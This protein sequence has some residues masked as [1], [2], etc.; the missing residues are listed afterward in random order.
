MGSK[1]PDETK[2]MSMAHKEV[3]WDMRTL[4]DEYQ[5]NESFLSTNHLRTHRFVRCVFLLSVPLLR[6]AVSERAGICAKKHRYVS[7]RKMWPCNSAARMSQQGI[8]TS[9]VSFLLTGY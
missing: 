4:A 7:V 2:Y 5:H 3:K 8:S 9:G 6:T 1:G